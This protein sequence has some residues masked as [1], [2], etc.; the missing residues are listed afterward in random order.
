MPQRGRD[1]TVKDKWEQVRA[2]LEQYGELMLAAGAAVVVAGLAV[3]T[4]VTANTLSAA[5]L[6]VL[7]AL[8]AAIVRERLERH[9]TIEMAQVLAADTRTEMRQLAEEIKAHSAGALGDMR[10]L[11]QATEGDEPWRVL[12]ES[13]TWDL[14]TRRQMNVT[15][16]R[17]IRFLHAQSAAVWEWFRS[18][19][20]AD[21]IEH[22]CEGGLTTRPLRSWPVLPEPFLGRDS[23]WYRVVSTAQIFK[24]GDRAD[25]ITTRSHQDSFPHPHTEGV[26]KTIEMP[27]DD[28]RLKVIWPKDYPPISVLFERAS[29]QMDLETQEDHEGR[30]FAIVAIATPAVHERLAIRWDWDAPLK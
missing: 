29:Q 12:D 1:P 26:S 19:N 9:R 18:P 15:D 25:W 11:A 20:G 6:G 4:D 3:S 5:T 14:T 24:R 13:I 22:S 17:T 2:V 16:K 30:Q 21:L 7:A 23:R 28:I 10:E 27:T 8:A